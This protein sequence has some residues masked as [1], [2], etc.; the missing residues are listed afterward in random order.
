MTTFL[1]TV[2]TWNLEHITEKL[3]E[4]LGRIMQ[5]IMSIITSASPRLNALLVQCEFATNPSI[6]V[7]LTD[8][9][10]TYCYE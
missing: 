6:K 2:L 10:E 9:V 4:I 7:E 1:G 5:G 8:T 3:Q